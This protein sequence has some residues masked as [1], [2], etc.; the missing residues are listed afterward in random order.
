MWHSIKQIANNYSE[1]SQMRKDKKLFVAKDFI[2]FAIE[3]SKKYD[4]IPHEYIE[5]DYEVNTWNSDN[6]INDYKKTL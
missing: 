5:G 2:N 4:I 3:N 6:L 1:L